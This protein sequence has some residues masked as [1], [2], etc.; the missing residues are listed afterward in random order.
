[1]IRAIRD[2]VPPEDVGVTLPHEHVLHSIGAVAAATVPNDDL[3][4]R[5]EELVGYRRTPFAHGGRNLLL[6]NE[7][8]AF[9]ELERM[10]L[11]R[12]GKLKPL[13]VDVTLPAEGR[14]VFVKERLH[15]AERLKNLNLLTVTTF[16]MERITDEFAIGLTPAQ[17]SER[18]AKTLEAELMFGM[19]GA[20]GVAF[21]GA[22]YQQIHAASGELG[23]KDE[24][25]AQG[26]AL[27]RGGAW[28]DDMV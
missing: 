18:I 26:L 13:V 22:I 1:M 16:A 23:A 21:P 17:Q 3:E 14:D 10:Q 19:E 24:I 12:D 6:Q 20:D 25:L 5:F 7:D 8:E 27:V 15:L 2:L 9:R 28:L 4:I 11:L